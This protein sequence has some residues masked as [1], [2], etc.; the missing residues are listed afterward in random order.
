MQ[1]H[2]TAAENIALGNLAVTPSEAEVTAAARAAGADVPI[3]RLPHGYE[4]VLGKWFGGAELSV[5]EWQRVAL[6]R[7]FLRQVPILVLD[8]P[9]SAMDSWAEAEWL[10][11]FRWL[12]DGRTVIIITHRFTTAM[13]ADIIHIMDEG[14]IVEAGRHEELLAHGGRYAQTWAT[15]MRTRTGMLTPH[16]AIGTIGP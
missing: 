11:R 1:Y 6:A 4:T 9:T 12:A 10:E 15:Q 14:R 7:A 5:G 8:E 2:A 3:A 16:Q 13:Q